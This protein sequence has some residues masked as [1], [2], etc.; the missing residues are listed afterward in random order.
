MML[1]SITVL[2]SCGTRKADGRQQ[3]RM[4]D[5]QLMAFLKYLIS[6]SK[7][8]FVKLIEA[9]AILSTGMEHHARHYSSIIVKDITDE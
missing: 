9:Y 1:M 2:K 8:H 7:T 6:K 3:L 4:Q 5:H